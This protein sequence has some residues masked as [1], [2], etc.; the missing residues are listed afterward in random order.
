MNGSILCVLPFPS[1]PV[2]MYQGGEEDNET[3][4]LLMKKQGL[5]GNLQSKS[6]LLRRNSLP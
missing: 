3:E 1:G 4:A 5:L 2:C 6:K